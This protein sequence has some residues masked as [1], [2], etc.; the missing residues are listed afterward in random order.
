MKAGIMIIWALA[1]AAWAMPA[2][3]AEKN[4]PPR[5]NVLLIMSDDLAVTL[6][7]FGHP[8]AVTPNLDALARRGV[9]FERAYCQFPHCNP[10]RASMM[11]GLRPN[12]TGVTG[13]A[14]N[15]YKNVPGIVTLPRLFRQHGYETARSGKIFHLGVPGGDQSMD[16]PE[17]WDFGRP[18][19]DER[20]YPASRESVVKVK[21]GKKEGL[22]WEEIPGDDDRLI[23]GQIAKTAIDW[24]ERRDR[25]K[26]FFLAVGFHRPHLPFVAPAKYFDL[27]P[28]DKIT[29]PKEPA[30]DEGDIPLPARNG[31]VGQYDMTATPEQRRAAIRAY[32]AT[33]SYMDAQAGRLLDVLKR[34]GVADNT[35]IVFTGDHGWHL[36]EHGLWH[37]RSLFEESAR[38]PLIVHS[39]GAKANGRAS[40]SLAELVDVYPTLCDLAG[41]PAPAVLEGK[42]LRPVLA[43]PA[44]VLREGAFTQ[45]RRGANAAHWGRSVRTLKWRC[46]E[47]DE[48]R[49][50]VELYDH[51][52][53]PHEYTNLASDPRHAGVLKELRATLAARVPATAAK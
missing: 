28:M 43:D 23:D 30:D 25:S 20:P 10:S 6:G 18:F 50:G 2:R 9:R 16:D 45:A 21:S 29:L 36:G 53:D 15:L 13:N 41:V 31:A 52:N 7:A 5:P 34:M 37:K 12:S 35:I 1:L 11:S 39:P 49:N 33:V 19:A 42:S 3:A 22:P 40:G 46:T 51:V 24:L 14:D 47:W 38:V 32:L 26:P 17:A 44:A 4:T 27:Y 8:V 48:G